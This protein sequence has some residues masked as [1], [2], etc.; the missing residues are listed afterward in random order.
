L[1]VYTRCP[2]I[3]REV[4]S[5]KKPARRRARR[6][7]QVWAQRIGLVLVGLVLPMLLV[8]GFL[9]VAGAAVPGE[10]QTASFLESHPEFGRR[11]RPGQGWKRT[12]EYTSWIEI[13]SKGLRGPEVQYEKPADEFRLLVLGD[14]FTFAEQVNQNETF[15]QGLE[16][17]LNST[18]ASVRFRTLNA[19]SNG[20]ATAN[21][22]VYLVEEGVKFQP[23]LV[24]LALYIGNDVSDNYRR[25]ATVRDAERADLAL[26]GADAFE[27]PRRILRRSMLYT[28]IETGVLAKLP[29]WPAA[30]ESDASLRRG[31]RTYEEAQEAWS[32]T[33]SLLD[34][35]RQVAESQGARFV[36]LVI[37][38][39]DEVAAGPRAKE[40]GSLDEGGDEENVPGFEDPHGTL[41]QMGSR[42]RLTMLDLLPTFRQQA[43]RS[44]E[45][46]FYRVNAHWTAA[47]HALTARKLYDVL[48]AD[49]LVPTR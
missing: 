3:T 46:L 26:R 6:P 34:R 48:T 25:V 39:A 36:L 47:G 44:R 27:G 45:R 10:Y 13:N 35:A 40:P 49:G 18:G 33:A 5:D 38:A 22:L 20:W 9:R 31:P 4:K 32:I 14:S 28:V 1:A 30:G 7:G 12:P 15:V 2:R 42:L 24:L 16:D 41:A 11:N 29:W 19:G 21:E 43:S 8:E 23:D 17:R 37:P